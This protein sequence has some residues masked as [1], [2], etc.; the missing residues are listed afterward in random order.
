MLLYDGTSSIDWYY[1]G[2]KTREEMD[3][4]LTY[5]PSDVPCVLYDDGSG[6]VYDWLYLSVL[7]KK[8]DVDF[9]KGLDDY[10]ETFKALEKSIEN[11]PEDPTLASV[12]AKATEAKTTADAAT[13][14]IGELGVMAADAQLTNSQLAQAVAELGVLVAGISEE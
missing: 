14:A 7:C 12:D 10:S 6:K 4:D 5:P 1:R 3:G 11:W 9:E 13:L 8:Y 2:F